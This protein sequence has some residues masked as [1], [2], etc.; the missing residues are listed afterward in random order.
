MH[1]RPRRQTL[2][3][4]C[5]LIYVIAGMVRTQGLILCVCD[6]RMQLGF[7]DNSGNC[8]CCAAAAVIAGS[9]V[10]GDVCCVDHGILSHEQPAAA[11][12]HACHCFDVPLLVG[13]DE[14][15][16]QD[17]IA[18]DRVPMPDAFV[19][20]VLTAAAGWPRIPAPASGRTSWHA[21]PSSQAPPQL[22]RTVLLLV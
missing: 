9:I 2:V 7:A 14:R 21:P 11:A 10:G 18:R 16:P 4:L 6:G 5:L 19:G 20:P 1:C 15:L 8:D 17:A 13:R 22:R 12:D 3:W